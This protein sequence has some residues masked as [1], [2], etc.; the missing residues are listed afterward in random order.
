MLR[1]NGDF[2]VFPIL[3]ATALWKEL[4][5]FNRVAASSP[6]CKAGDRPPDAPGLKLLLVS[7]PK[8][9]DS[10]GGATH[11]QNF[12]FVIPSLTFLSSNPY[13]DPS[14]SADDPEMIV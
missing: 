7:T 2:E 8:L 14:G 13:N 9:A 11:T 1:P 4:I 6:R 10:L 5:Q 12:D 3:F